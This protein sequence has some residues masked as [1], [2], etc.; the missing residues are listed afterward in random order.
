ME[1]ALESGKARSIGVSNFMPHHLVD[2]TEEVSVTP[3]VNQLEVN[4]FQ[5]AQEARAACLDLGVQCQGYS[6][7]AKANCLSDPRLVSIANQAGATP[8]QVLIKWCLDKGIP[9]IPKTTRTQRVQENLQAFDVHLDQKHTSVLDSMHCD[10]R[11]TWDPSCV[12]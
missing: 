4:A 10:L 8:A 5:Q 12:P 7:L 2:L 1:L 11:V 3:M 9:T 6:P